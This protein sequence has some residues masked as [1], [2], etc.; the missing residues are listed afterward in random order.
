MTRTLWRVFPWDP[1]AGEGEPFSPRFLPRQSGQGRFDLP[2][3]V[4]A[5]AWYFAESPEHAVAEKVQDLRGG[6]LHDEFLFERGRRLAICSVELDPSLPLADLCDPQE[7]ARRNI[8]PDRL[9]FRDRTVT[10]A[11]AGDLYLDPALAG[12]R[13]W[14]ALFGEWHTVVPFS[15]RLRND[16]LT[17]ST[18][19][20]LEPGSPAVVAAAA[21]LAIEIDAG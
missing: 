7:L 1:R 12:F 16:S 15:D 18:P 14:S 6:V 11:I 20:P 10:R 8:A 17:F 3:S 5:S 21:A 9:A 19:E 4:G 2:L 13:W